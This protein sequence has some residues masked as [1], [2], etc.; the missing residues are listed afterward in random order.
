MAFDI[1]L[2]FFGCITLSL[3]KEM[4]PAYFAGGGFSCVV[5]HK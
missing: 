2:T 1:K 3:C 4:V 5:L